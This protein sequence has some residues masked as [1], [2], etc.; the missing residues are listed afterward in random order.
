M[1]PK[2]K[3]RL[4]KPTRTQSFIFVVLLALTAAAGYLLAPTHTP[5]PQATLIYQPSKTQKNLIPLTPSPSPV[6]TEY[7]HTPE[8]ETT[9]LP[10]KTLTKTPQKEVKLAIVIDDMGND[11][12]QTKEAMVLLPKSVTFAF[13]P[14]PP[15][16][17]ALAAES[18]AT[19]HTILV[20]MPSEPLGEDAYPGPNTLKAEDD[21]DTLRSKIAINLAPLANLAV[22]VNNHMGS[23]FTQSESGMR[24]L[25]EE[26]DKKGY[27][28]LDSLTINPTATK[29]AGKGLSLP[30]L[31]RNI[32]LDH[33]PTE[34]EVSK[35]LARAISYAEAHGTAIAI[36]HPHPATL[37][38][39]SR[40][41][42]NLPAHV[43][44]VP[45]TAL[46]P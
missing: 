14:Y 28:F 32:F 3:R 2:R 17:P 6:I 38:I 21:A 31:T 37:T 24:T 9:P 18:K 16:T 35:Q 23:K 19:G 12:P 45:L 5:S 4:N 11:V 43:K 30:L 1:P 7:P 27:F 29:K 42:L 34:E 25:L 46:L 10:P 15:A 36:G 22:G 26:L 33:V 41:I 8:P 40:E 20:H 44:L 39:L 13:L